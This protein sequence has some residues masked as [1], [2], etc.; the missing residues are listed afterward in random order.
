[1]FHDGEAW[2]IEAVEAAAPWYFE[3]LNV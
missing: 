2:V 1:M 3:S